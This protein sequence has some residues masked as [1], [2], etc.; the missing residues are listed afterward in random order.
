MSEWQAAWKTAN[1]EPFEDKFQDP[2]HTGSVWEYL[3]VNSCR[4]LKAFEN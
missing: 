1:D 4:T 2:A 3:V